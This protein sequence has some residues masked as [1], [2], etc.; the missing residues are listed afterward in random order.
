MKIAH[1]KHAALCGLA[2]VF[3]FLSANQAMAA[4]FSCTGPLTYLGFF[5]TGRLAASINGQGVWSICSTDGTWNGVNAAACKNWYGALLTAYSTQKPVELY[6][7]TANSANSSIAAGDC[8]KANM[9]H[10]VARPP[11]FLHVPN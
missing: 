9:G 8:S 10:W 7:D 2:G 3:L 5:D 1:F 4:K 6:F 11:Y